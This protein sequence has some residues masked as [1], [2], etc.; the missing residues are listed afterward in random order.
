MA[1]GSLRRDPSHQSALFRFILDWRRVKSPS[2]VDTLKKKKQKKQKKEKEKSNLV[3]E[4]EHLS[5]GRI[6]F[7]KL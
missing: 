6:L 3:L 5:F 4:D 1:L 2:C 7:L